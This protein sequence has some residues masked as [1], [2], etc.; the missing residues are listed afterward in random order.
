VPTNTNNV[1]KKQAKIFVEK[2]P[3]SASLNQDTPA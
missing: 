3:S 2:M 1:Y